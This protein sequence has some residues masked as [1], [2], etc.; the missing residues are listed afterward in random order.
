[1]DVISQIS[2]EAALSSDDL[3]RAAR[4]V[5]EQLDR[6]EGEL[7]ALQAAHS[8]TLAQYKRDAKG[9]LRRYLKADAE[10]LSV[11][12]VGPLVGE[13]GP[14]GLDVD[15]LLPD[16]EAVGRDQAF[17]EAGR[18]AAEGSVDPI[19]VSHGD[20]TVTVRR[21]FSVL[22]DSTA[23]SPEAARL[24]ALVHASRNSKMLRTL[25]QQA[26]LFM[27]ECYL[28]AH[29]YDLD[30]VRFQG[31]AAFQQHLA[32]LLEAIYCM[33]EEQR[34]AHLDSSTVDAVVRRP[35]EQL[36]VDLDRFYQVTHAVL[37]SGPCSDV[38][39]RA[40]ALVGRGLCEALWALVSGACAAAGVSDDCLCSLAE[41][42]R[43]ALDFHDSCCVSASVSRRQRHTARHRLFALAELID[44][45]GTL[46]TW[47][48]A[49]RRKTFSRHLLPG[50]YALLIR[51]VFA[52]SSLRA[53]CL[54]ELQLAEQDP[55]SEGSLEEGDDLE[56][57]E[58]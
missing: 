25:P 20:V 38:Y 54:R 14:L 13:L 27:N 56:E 24:Y 39:A 10:V 6:E 51:G 22:L 9:L 43:E 36:L 58:F 49:F 7:R 34:G 45:G 17:R 37:G 26:A 11:S 46:L 55:S 42:I 57:D 50:D 23:K 1:M 29:L 5:Q 53:A 4:V 15:G 32:S 31:A 47:I 19:A 28:L 16:Y 12:E 40:M 33:R 30:D 35:V 41:G 21:G 44:A 18:M 3:K 8:T 2:G 48:G 52:D